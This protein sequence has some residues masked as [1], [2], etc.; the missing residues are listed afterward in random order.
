MTSKKVKKRALEEVDK[1]I[2]LCQEYTQMW[3]HFFNFF[4]DG[5]ES[6]KITPEA[7]AQFFQVMTDLARKQYRLRYFLQD[8]CPNDE[9]I[10]NILGDGVSL[11]NIHEMTEAQFNKMQHT[12]HVIFIA[13]NKSLGRLMQ[14]RALYVD[15]KDKT[16]KKTGSKNAP[17]DAQ[18]DHAAAS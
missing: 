16:G 5:F 3:A 14:K 1:K 11:A 12:W 2:K 4:A 7:E 8:D 15:E 6:R 17:Q 13:L 10:L 9:K 18:A